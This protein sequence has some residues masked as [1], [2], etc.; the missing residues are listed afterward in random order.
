MTTVTYHPMRQPIDEAS[1]DYVYIGRPSKWGNPFVIGRDGGRP[2]VIRKFRDWWYAPGQASLRAAALTELKDTVLGCY[3]YPKPCHG[4]VIAA[5]VN[6]HHAG[7]SS[8][9]AIE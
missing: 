6:E 7:H 3:C 8:P 9:S 4:N 5:Y 1:G 2:D